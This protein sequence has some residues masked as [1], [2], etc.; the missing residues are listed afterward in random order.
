MLGRV[1]RPWRLMRGG[2]KQGR[3]RSAEHKAWIRRQVCEGCGTKGG[4]ANPI[5]AAHVRI[6]GLGGMGLK[7]G[8]ERCVPLC[9][10]C[11]LGQ[12]NE[13]ETTFWERIKKDP[14]LIIDELV[15][16]SPCQKVRG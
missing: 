12:H 3:V 7:P 4:P 1:P 11:H 10:V 5:Q 16:R 6:R 14:E 13:G 8:D 15:K 9:Y 2:H